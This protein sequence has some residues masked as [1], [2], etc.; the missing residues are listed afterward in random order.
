MAWEAYVLK[1]NRR[2]IVTTLTL[3]LIAV[4]PASQADELDGEGRRVF[5]EIAGVGCATCHGE[6]A[7]GDVSIGPY[8]RGASEGTIRAAIEAVDEMIVVKSAIT[9][10]EIA[11][12]VE[13]VQYLGS[14][15]VARTLMKRGRFLPAE[16]SVKPATSVQVIISNAGFSE[17]VLASDDMAIDEFSLAGRSTASFVWQA[18]D[19]DGVF[20]LSCADCKLKD[21][22]FTISVDTNAPEQTN[23]V[24][25]TQ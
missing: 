17:S 21:Q 13:Y 5:Q 11:A 2:S 25:V 7:E 19:S 22:F 18:P 23:N 8:I 14:L 3:L 10:G 24:Q 6:F 1:L 20:A 9:D 16:I 4:V 12:V 15:Q